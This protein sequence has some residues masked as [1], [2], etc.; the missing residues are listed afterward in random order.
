MNLVLIVLEK[1]PRLVE[2]R[3]ILLA[4]CFDKCSEI[5]SMTTCPILVTKWRAVEC[6]N[7]H[8]N[9]NLVIQILSKSKITLKKLLFWSWTEEFILP[10]GPKGLGLKS[11]GLKS[12][13]LKSLGL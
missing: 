2:T 3:I 7:E 1:G 5:E 4:I 10:L 8:G 11:L 12:S 13:G 6:L 9:E